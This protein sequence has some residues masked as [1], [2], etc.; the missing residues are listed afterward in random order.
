MMRKSIT[1]LAVTVALAGAVGCSAQGGTTVPAKAQTPVAT[2]QQQRQASKEWAEEQARTPTTTPTTTTSTTPAQEQAHVE[3][4][5][6][7]S[8]GC[9][10]REQAKAKAYGEKAR[11]EERLSRESSGRPES[12]QEKEIC[13]ASEQHQACE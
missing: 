10:A 3:K 9:V 11:L 12:R 8:P 4:A 1:G 6:C 13:E 7:G 5:Q 2:P